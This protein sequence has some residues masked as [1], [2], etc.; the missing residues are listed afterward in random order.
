MYMD[1]VLSRYQMEQ[2]KK[3]LLFVR[4][5][6]HF[7]KSMGP[8]TPEEIRQICTRPDIV[9]DVSITSRYQSNPRLEH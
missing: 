2:S 5:G 9:Y 8:K 6:I 4:H 7:S 3:S 1:K